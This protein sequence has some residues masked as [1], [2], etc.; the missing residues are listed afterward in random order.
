M[1]SASQ[2]HLQNDGPGPSLIV[3]CLTR[4]LLELAD[5]S[6]GPLELLL[7]DQALDLLP[8]VFLDLDLTA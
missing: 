5:D 2:L 7:R 1:E 8:G 6:R 4:R 3:P